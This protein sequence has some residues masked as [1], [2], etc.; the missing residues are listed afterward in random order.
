MN[1][2]LSLFFLCVPALAQKDVQGTGSNVDL[3]TMD[4]ED[5]M[6]VKVTSVSRTEEK[7]SR[8]ASAVFVITQADIARSGAA[9]I[10]GLLRMVPGLD[11]AQIDANTWA[12]SARGLN[13]EFSNELLVL[14][15]GRNVYT[16]TFGG[17]L[18]GLLD[19]PLENIERIE[20]IRGPGGSIWG[21]NAVNGVINI[22]TKKAGE[23][24]GVMVVAGGGNL[25]KGFGTAQ[26][27]GSLGKDTDFRVYSKYFNQDHSPAATG[28]S[29]GDGW[30]TLRGGFRTDSTLSMKDTLMLQGDLFT[31]REGESVVSLPSITSSGLINTQTVAGESG[32][33]FQGVWRHTYSSRSDTT[34]S[35]SYGTYESDDVLN[36][37][38]EGRKTFSADFQEHIAWGERQDFVWGLGYQYSTSHSEGNLTVSLNPANLST[39]LFSS[40]VQDEIALLP[41]RF[42][43]TVGAKLEH[44]YYTGFT[45]MPSARGAYLIS[46]GQMLWAAFSKAERTPAS[47]D[48]AI[49]ENFGSSPG[50]GGIPVLI[51]LLGN[52]Q[53]KNEVLIDYELGYR[54]S[55][56]KRLSIDLA[57]Y[58]NDYSNQQTT[59]P[60][61]EFLE[62]TPTPVHLVMPSTYENLMHGE[63]HGFEVAANWKV[64][65]RWTVSPAYDFERF[66][67]HLSPSSQDT[68]TVADVEGTDPHVHAHLR[69]HV[70]LS[71]GLSWDVSAYFVDRI[72]YQAVPSYTR[73]DTQLSW[74][75]KEGF[76]VSLV[77]QN[78]VRDSHLEFVEQGNDPTLVKRSGYAKVTWKF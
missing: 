19:L 47:V 26:Y 24:R 50:P 6:N 40:F 34:F 59:E 23:T 48:T 3:S 54:I 64:T 72:T 7:L 52:P 57:A 35:A 62:A 8:T 29:A 27:G 43:L 32:G 39:Q 63:A 36:S 28:Q 22:I 58:Y 55:L 42:Y 38:A 31:G 45:V 61:A 73:L 11:V 14:F 30:H 60:A 49:R 2:S 44:N 20:V 37:I 70:D 17:V 46:E 15:D 41:D 4:I 68:T 1:C 77:G 66:H 65:D 74:R 18:W 76:S 5:L 25:D 51:S 53:F 16:P 12:I 75:P 69:S 33:F 67:M 78:L 56:S 13:D 71:N 21:A 9:N 10:P